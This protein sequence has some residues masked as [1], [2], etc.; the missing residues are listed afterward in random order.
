MPRAVDALAGLALAAGLFARTFRGDRSKFWEHMTETGAVLG[1]MALA[2]DR[3]ARPSGF[4]PR[5]V[6]LGL[7][8]AAGLYGIFQAGDRMARRVMPRGSAEIAEIYELRTLRPEPEI[9]ARLAL[10]I[11]PAEELFWRGLVF[12]G[13]ASRYGRLG[14]WL[15]S[16]AAYGGVHVASANATLIGAAS[17]AGLWWGALAALG[18]PMAALITSHIVWDIWIFLV[19]PTE[20][21]ASA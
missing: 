11:G 9:A 7:A 19:R 12:H 10:V 14:G 8:I 21:R 2:E 18:A 15:L 4:G 13:L 20:Q 16:S 5:S 6:A 1:V 3:R 17:V